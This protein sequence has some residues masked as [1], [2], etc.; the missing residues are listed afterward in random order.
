[1]KSLKKIATFAASAFISVCFLV[2]CGKSVSVSIDDDFI[3]DID[4][5]PT[6]K[7]VYEDYSKQAIDSYF[8][9]ANQ[10]T[11]EWGDI[12]FD[13]EEVKAAVTGAAISAATK[14]FAY[15]CYNERMLDQ[16]VYFSA[17][18]GKTD[19]GK[20]GSATALR[21]EYY[22]RI[23]ENENSC[24][25]RYHY[26]IKKVAESEGGVSMM[27]SLFESA[28]TRITTDTNLLY[29]LELKGSEI[30]IGPENKTLGEKILQCEWKRGDEWG[31]P[32][33]E[34]VKSPFVEPENI[35]ADIES[36]AGQDNITMRANINILADNIVKNA[37]IIK[38][39][40][41]D[42]YLI[43]MTIDTE[44]A[45][46]DEASLAMLR[47]ANGSSDCV[48]KDEASDEDDEDDSGLSIVFRIWS[49]GLFRFYSVAERWQGNISGFGGVAES[50][51][52]YHYSYS[53]RD[54]DVSR[55]LEPLGIYHTEQE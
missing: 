45:N 17:Q 34:M 39:E 12:D 44:V 36:V 2:G 43:T 19:L 40:S 3:Q 10:Y 55:Y 48:W 47:K 5:Y 9:V 13:N 14:L 24:G 11:D 33:I 26:T 38:D 23:N 35:R 41:A 31:V 18:E 1:M 42:G 20:S 22:L 28:R 51:T 49:N 29:R 8:A 27:T 46:K 30:K 54:C 21:Q 15:A 37:V 52:V 50:L 6:Q 7:A 25:Y 16:Y 32:N 53:D 4:V